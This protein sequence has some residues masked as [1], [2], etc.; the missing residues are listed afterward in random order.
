V[1]A[2]AGCI[3]P[4][5]RACVEC[6]YCIVAGIVCIGIFLPVV[7][8]ASDKIVDLHDFARIGPKENIIA[9]GLQRWVI[10]GLSETLH[11]TSQHSQMS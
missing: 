10:E 8:P 2:A 4:A 5:R 11:S 6:T 7:Y 9:R 3:S 1:G